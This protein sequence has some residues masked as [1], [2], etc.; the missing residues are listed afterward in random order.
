MSM[1]WLSGRHEEKRRREVRREEVKR[2]ES[3]EANS[4]SAANNSVDYL[5]E[6]SLDYFGLKFS[7]VFDLN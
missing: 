6:F 3:G 2:G 4:H 1:S 5:L 7:T